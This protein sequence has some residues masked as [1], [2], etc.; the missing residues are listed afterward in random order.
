MKSSS[1]DVAVSVQGYALL[2]K[3]EYTTCVV[4]DKDVERSKTMFKR[5][6]VPLDGSAGAERAIPVSARIARASVGT[7]VFVRVV[8]A[9]N[10]VGTYT[11][12]ANDS[13][14]V[15]P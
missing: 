11:P 13:T 6:L 2:K 14:T 15:P 3:K 1:C 12:A 10:E 5:I 4:N 7:I 8:P 9:I